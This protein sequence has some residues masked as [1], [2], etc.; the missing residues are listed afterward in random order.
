MNLTVDQDYLFGKTEVPQR[1]RVLVLGIGGAGGNM[2]RRMAAR[3][4]NGGPDVAVVDTDP[5][6]LADCPVNTSLLLGEL[7]TQRL[8]SGSDTEA[9]RMAAEES[10]GRLEPI[11]VGYD[12]VFLVCGLGGGTGTGAAP[13]IADYLHKLETLTLCFA[14][15]PFGFEGDRRNRT[16][17]DGVR[18]LQDKCDAV[19]ILPNEKL[20]DLLEP[21]TGLESSFRISDDHV[22]TC[23]YALWKLLSRPGVINL[24]F[25]DVRKL[26]ERSGGLC[27]FGHGTGQGKTRSADAIRTLLSS[28]W[29]EQGAELGHAASLMINILGG[30]DM[31]LADVQGV[32]GEITAKAPKGIQ[33]FVG[34]SVDGDWRDRLAITVLTAEQWRDPVISRD[35]ADE[36]VTDYLDNLEPP[37]E[38]RESSPSAAAGGIKTPVQSDL[39][40]EKATSEGRGRFSAAEPTIINGQDI[41]IPTYLRRGLK[42]SFER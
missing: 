21:Q 17:E 31:T 5:Q 30:P 41:D 29:L 42:L 38:G 2:V 37:Q 33:L 11:L 22:A 7:T 3:W 14:A 34:A 16:A 1:S 6:S 15:M 26:V 4:P 8:S 27:S 39:P 32:I 24:D 9:G 12:L 18:T 19:I 40:L 25:A 23:I 10:M 35:E 13:V 20:I 28:P 36:I